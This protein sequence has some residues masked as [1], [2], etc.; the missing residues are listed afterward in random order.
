MSPFFQ[1]KNKNKTSLSNLIISCV[2]TVRLIEY[3]S[4]LI[5]NIGV[6]KASNFSHRFFYKWLDC[7][8][9]MNLLWHELTN[10]KKD[11]Y[12]IKY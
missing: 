8:Q 7:S 5:S 4:R 3:S 9:F 1:K 6:L 2:V 10:K 12:F 11:N